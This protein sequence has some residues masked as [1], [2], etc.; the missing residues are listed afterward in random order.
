MKRLLFLSIFIGICLVSKAKNDHFSF[1]YPDSIA[2]NADAVILFNRITYTRTSLSNLNE[3]VHYALTIFGERGKDYREF[4]ILYDP[5]T[6]VK[7]LTCTIY[8]QQ[9]NKV[10]KLKGSDIRDF[11]NYSSYTFFHDNRV[12][13]FEANHPHYPYT[14]EVEYEIDH[15]GFIG[16]DSWYPIENY[17]VGVREATLTVIFPY[18]LPIKYKGANVDGIVFSEV[19]EQNNRRLVWTLRNAAPIE[20]ERFAPPFSKQV[21]VVYLAP[22]QFEYDKSKGEFSSWEAMGK[23]NSGLLCNDYQMSDKTMTDLDA[24]KAKSLDQRDLVK[25]VYRYMQAKTRYVGIQLGIGGY[26][27]MSPTLVDEVGYGDCKALSYYTKAL[28]SRVGVNSKYAVIGIDRQRIQF[29][30][31]ASV[32]QMNHVILCVPDTKDTIWLE[33]TSQN[34]PFNHLFDGTT[35]RKALLIEEG[36]IVKTPD[37]KTGCKN[38]WAE[39][40]L[41]NTG[42]ISGKIATNYSGAFYDD[43]YPLKTYSAKELNEYVQRTSTVSGFSS[44]AISVE[45]VDSIPDLTLKN[46]FSANNFAPVSGDRIFVE[47]SPFTQMAKV[48]EQR[49]SRRNPVYLTSAKIYKDKVVFHIPDGFYIEYH[50]ETIVFDSKFGSYAMQIHID[51][52]EV[53][54]SRVFSLNKG[55]YEKV[56]YLGFINFIGKVSDSDHCKLILKKI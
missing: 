52:Q 15:D 40:Y 29:D 49:E 16:L 36:K 2:K 1:D 53:I 6:A 34:A 54:Y 37:A 3:H 20:Y 13:Y 31:F 51:K 11:S 23:W 44:D 42:K 9:G 45:E 43:Y 4:T 8:D 18:D 24:I 17:N 39:L 19:K 41:D 35:G 50:P 14:I 46:D 28:L 10:R 33:C 55:E 25:K 27:P 26:T 30:D 21:P 47:L 32:N 22:V 56:D 38:Q 12:K 48:A 7:K 5:F